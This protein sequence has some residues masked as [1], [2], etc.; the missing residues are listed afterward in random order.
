[1]GT[2]AYS[3]ETNDAGPLEAL[4]E[5]SGVGWSLLVW[6]GILVELKWT[7]WEAGAREDLIQLVLSVD[8][9]VTAIGRVTA[10]QLMG[11]VPVWDLFGAK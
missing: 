10:I 9:I 2:I 11:A 1:M 5:P 3:S 4:D 7:T 6:S 8:R